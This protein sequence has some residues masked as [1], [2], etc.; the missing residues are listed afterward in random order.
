MCS[1]LELYVITSPFKDKM[2]GQRTESFKLNIN[3]I[4]I[5]NIFLLAAHTVLTGHKIPPVPNHTMLYPVCSWGIRG[6]KT[7]G[8]LPRNTESH[9]PD[10]P[11]ETASPEL[12]KPSPE[13]AALIST[14][15]HSYAFS[16]VFP[17]LR[18]QG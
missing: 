15:G 2:A 13:V 9:T 5:F 3:C 18:K 1:Y 17:F 14:Q 11:A 7:T 12:Y 10:I 6:T 4:I 8:L 16:E